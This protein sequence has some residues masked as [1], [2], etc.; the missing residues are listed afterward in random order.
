M[1][2]QNY[3][4]VS[5]SGTSDKKNCLVLIL[6]VPVSCITQIG[7]IVVVFDCDILWS[8]PENFLES[9]TSAV[10]ERM[11]YLPDSNGSYSQWAGVVHYADWLHSFCI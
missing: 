2:A 8:L 6:S 7:Y 9:A 1:H 5:Q 4:I 11:G 10:A 3:K